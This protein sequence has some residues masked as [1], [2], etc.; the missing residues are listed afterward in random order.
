M[1]IEES[2]E[3]I[4]GA[5]ETVAAAQTDL[6]KVARWNRERIESRASD[7]EPSAPCEK[8]CTHTAPPAPGEPA[9]EGGGEM[10]YEEMKAKLTEAGVTVPP[11]TRA[12]TLRKWLDNPGTIPQECLEK[13]E[14]GPFDGGLEEPETSL[15]ENLPCDASALRDYFSTQLAYTGEA[16]QV[17]ALRKALEELGTTSL[18]DC[19]VDKYPALIAAYR[20]NLGE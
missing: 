12:A 5:L 16:K 4:A 10:S 3:R 13:K 1:S 18:R 14:D 20:T 11:R 19:P 7:C 8:A 15:P 9:V 2:L 6:L 17:A